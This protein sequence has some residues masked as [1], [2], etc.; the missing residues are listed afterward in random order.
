MKNRLI[1]EIVSLKERKKLL[2]AVEKGEHHI[3]IFTDNE[4]R[5]ALELK[6]KNLL[7]Q[8][9][10]RINM[11]LDEDERKLRRTHKRMH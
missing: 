8:E 4:L 11:L 5:D 7:K 2:E 1:N 6:Q 10:N 3:D 9:I